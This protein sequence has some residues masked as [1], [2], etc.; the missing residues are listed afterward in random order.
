MAALEGLLAFCSPPV[1]RSFPPCPPPHTHT[2]PP[3]HRR[4][5]EP[6][7]CE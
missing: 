4:K 2:S 1:C 6:R 5:G 7:E 3:V